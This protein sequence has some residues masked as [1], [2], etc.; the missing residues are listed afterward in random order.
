MFYYYNDELNIYDFQFIK[1]SG[2]NVVD[3]TNIKCPQLEDG[4]ILFIPFF[5]Y[6]HIKDTPK[7]LIIFLYIN[8]DYA[9]P[10]FRNIILE[11]KLTEHLIFFSTS[12]LDEKT[13]SYDLSFNSKGISSKIY[14]NHLS[15]LNSKRTK[16]YNLFN[17][18][19]NIQ[20]LKIFELIK[21]KNIELSNCYYTF[22]NILPKAKD[23]TNQLIDLSIIHSDKINVQHRLNN[24]ILIP[25]T[26]NEYCISKKDNIVDI[27]F[28]NK[29]QNEF[30]TI[31]DRQKLESGGLEEVKLLG[32]IGDLISEQCIDSYIAFVTEGIDDSDE[33]LRLSEKT[34]RAMW[35]KNIFLPIQCAGFSSALRRFGIST[36][37]DVFELDKNWDDTDNLNRIEI[38]VSCIEKINELSIEEIEEIYNRKDI[39][40][41]LENNYKIIMES[42]N[43]DNLEKEI[44]CILKNISNKKM[45]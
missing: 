44:L 20:R 33:D 3:I 11:N 38:F 1:K 2:Y 37:E 27:D 43:S 39:Q 31:G 4:D 15:T 35:A 8:C 18:F 34:L 36:F 5:Y 41:R 26:L 21:K 32:S 25:K 17:R 24:G 13:L 28:I 30:K 23:D 7:R 16:K 42:F 9:H 22:A 6:N 45:I 19:A 29:F 12:H 14:V 10:K 40:H